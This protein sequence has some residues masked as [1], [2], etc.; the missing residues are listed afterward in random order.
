MAFW[1]NKHEGRDY[2]A[3]RA[4]PAMYTNPFALWRE[5]T[6]EGRMGVAPARPH[7]HTFSLT[8][9][10]RNEDGCVPGGGRDEGGGGLKRVA[11]PTLLCDTNFNLVT[12]Q[13]TPQLRM[14]RASERVVGSSR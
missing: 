9:R 8:R 6:E 12:Q 4:F 2:Q 13:T 14:K 7:S 5:G 10:R 11:L 1:L 3:Y